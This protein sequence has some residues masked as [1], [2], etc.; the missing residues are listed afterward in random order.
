MWSRLAWLIVPVRDVTCLI[1]GVWGVV[2]EELSASPDLNRLAF[3]GVLMTA[4][5]LLA[6]RWLG[7]GESSSSP[8]PSEPSPQP[9]S[10]TGGG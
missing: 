4:P 6:A 2:H 8:P 3:F 7:R 5:G 1:L 9:S 10:S